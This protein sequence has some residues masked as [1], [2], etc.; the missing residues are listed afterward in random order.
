MR[1]L[2]YGVHHEGPGGEQYPDERPRQAQD[3]ILVFKL[4]CPK[5]KLTDFV[6]VGNVGWQGGQLPMPRGSH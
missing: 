3:F 4:F 1:I 2:E 5:C 6:K